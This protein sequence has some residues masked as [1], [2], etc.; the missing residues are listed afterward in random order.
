[1]R[2]DPKYQNM[3]MPDPQVLY[4]D[5]ESLEIIRE[6]YEKYFDSEDLVSALTALLELANALSKEGHDEVAL[7]LIEI[8]VTGEEPLRKR[9]EKMN[10]PN[11]SD[12]NNFPKS[13][14]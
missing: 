1:M 7:E 5:H 2:V 12:E 11:Q 14:E 4:L 13:K 9:A 6:E 3:G 8:A 10:S